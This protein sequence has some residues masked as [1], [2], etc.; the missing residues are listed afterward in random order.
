MFGV[1]FFVMS[2]KTHVLSVDE[3]VFSVDDVFSYS[4]VDRRGMR[5]TVRVPLDVASNLV[6]AA[7]GLAG[8]VEAAE[9]KTLCY[10]ILRRILKVIT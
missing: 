6:I 5:P 8:D 7:R 1:S 9:N 10:S 3:L 2:T 4:V